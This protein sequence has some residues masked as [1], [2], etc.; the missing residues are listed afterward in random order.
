M[1]R[2]SFREGLFMRCLFVSAGTL[3]FF[4]L[5]GCGGGSGGA[6]T[7]SP[8]LE[9]P[10]VS[11]ISPSDATVGTSSLD[12]IVFGSN[13]ENGALVQWNGTALSTSWQSATQLTATVPASDL[14]AAGTANVTVTNPAPGG[15]VSAAR[16]FTISAGPTPAAWVRS[17]AG[18]V[19]PQD[20]VWDA[21]H[22]LLYV[23]VASTDPAAPNTIVPVNP[24]AGTAGTSVPAGT[25]PDLLSISSDSS[26]L[27]A[28]I[29]GSDAVQRFLLPSLTKDISFSLPP[30][31]W[32]N[33]QQAVCLQATP[34]SPH[35]VAVIAGNWTYSPAGNG[36]YVYDDAT[37]R[38]TSVEGYASGGP[39]IDWFQ[40]GANNSVIYGNQYTT[41]DRGGVATMNVTS[42][43]VSL[44]SYNGGQVTPDMPQYD[45]ANNLL[46]SNTWI[47]NPT[48]GSLVGTYNSPLFPLG[49]LACT[50]DSS[51]SRY[52]CLVVD[53]GVNNFE[54]WV[55]DLNTATL[56]NRVDF[57][58]TEGEPASFITGQPTHLVRWGNAGLALTT[59]TAPYVGSG[60][61]FLI[62]GP[63]VNPNSAP[64][65]ASGVGAPSYS[66]MT[67][68]V[69]QQAPAGSGDISVTINGT[70]FAPDSVACWNCGYP[71]SNFL[72]T[73]YVSPTR[74]NVTIPS[75][76]TAT[77]GPVPIR[78][79]DEATNLFSTDTL[80]FTVS[81]AST[82][83]PQV[84][85]LNLAGLAM[86]WDSQSGLIYVGVANFDGAY[87]NSI[88]A[89]NGA[90]GS[91]TQSQTVTADP[92]LLSA[93]ADGQ[94][95]YAGFLT[96]T[97]MTQLQLPALQSPLT[98]TLSNPQG[99]AVYTAGD[100]RVAP[101]SPHT[102]AVT[103]FNL[104]SNPDET[105]GVV[106]Y[107]DNVERPDFAPGFAGG[108]AVNALY[109]TIAWGSSDQILTAACFAVD[110]F[111]QDVP[112]NPLYEF[113]VTAP[114]A[115][116]VS[117][118]PSSFNQGDIHSDFGTG[119]IYSDDGNVADPATQTIVG[120]Y[121][122][123]GLVA[124]DSSLNRV[125]I[126][127][128]TQ[129]Q[130]NTSNFTI[131]SFDEKAYTTVSSITLND[132]HGTPSQLIR[133]GASGLAVLTY[134]PTFSAPG[135]LYLIQDTNFVSNAQ[136]VASGAARPRELVRCRWKRISKMDML[137]MLRRGTEPRS[138]G[139]V[140]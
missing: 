22:G 27:W 78:V 40:W 111:G 112:F 15:G 9:I 128:Q 35:A 54:L 90:N 84:T 136:S 130:T 1:G 55:W 7:T 94:Y 41:I 49:P 36:V 38:P 17:V 135:M 26:Y 116:F 11:A 125:F 44:V 5:A 69:P 43:G 106:I 46:Y 105:G 139:D 127:G 121:N 14:S 100:I 12:L 47:F 108:Q 75:T 113:Q 76:L 129:A 77:P 107:D 34:N 10:A 29:D 104:Q 45:A 24:A 95:L 91:V 83:G 33:P 140:K 103:L 79:F 23:S 56:I 42:A 71:P 48:N 114:G 133:W 3:L 51:T 64:D 16:T 58:T 92:Y 87:P 137:R 96:A 30:D 25:N 39:M 110:C 13:F 132:V 19:A 117:A 109:D 59:I 98:W 50:L 66:W 122:A 68:L 86:A 37:P 124:P 67:S 115:A 126:L 80:T 102:T 28:G 138:M 4:L 63:A 120:S 70:N 82:G 60:G 134:D 53:G 74:L 119:L 20:V 65:Y 31:P 8:S 99:S 89:I 73:S 62:D 97:V 2:L 93:S 61:V 18:I 32:G 57:G 131:E 85:A 88:V 21:A 123:S 6:V 52:Y 81:S 118:A 101:G 72:P